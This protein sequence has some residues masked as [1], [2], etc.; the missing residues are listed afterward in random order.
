MAY[1]AVAANNSRGSL[2]GEKYAAA[3]ANIIAQTGTVTKPVTIPGTN[4]MRI[5]ETIRMIRPRI[6]RAYLSLL[7]A[8]ASNGLYDNT[9]NN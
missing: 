2:V 3:T 7:Q 8:W 4:T 1:A 5:I 6:A 9:P